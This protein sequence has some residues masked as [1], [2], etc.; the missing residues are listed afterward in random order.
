M[1]LTGKNTHFSRFYNL[2]HITWT[3][4][5]TYINKILLLN[6]LW[7]QN[8][9]CNE[10]ILKHVVKLKLL[11]R[12]QH[13][14]LKNIQTI[15]VMFYLSL[16]S[17]TTTIPHHEQEIKQ[18]PLSK[19]FLMFH[20]SEL[21]FQPKSF[22]IYQNLMFQFREKLELVQSKVKWACE[23]FHVLK[24]CRGYIKVA[25][26]LLSQRYPTTIIQ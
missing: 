22:S 5:N 6:E 7:L 11:L 10:R 21:L 17:Y 14:H 25:T 15:L 4:D 1:S 9:S 2:Q 26:L 18:K 19:I 20:N 24:K 8:S 16:A 23:C 12:F 3:I 13:V